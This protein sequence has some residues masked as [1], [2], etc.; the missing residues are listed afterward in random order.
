MPRPL[1]WVPIGGGHRELLVRLRGLLLLLLLGFP[2]IYLN[3]GARGGE[4]GLYRED[5]LRLY[6]LLPQEVFSLARTEETACDPSPLECVWRLFVSRAFWRVGCVVRGCRKSTTSSRRSPHFT[7]EDAQN[8]N[9]LPA[10]YM[11]GFEKPTH[12]VLSKIRGWF[13]GTT[14]VHTGDDYC[15]TALYS[16]PCEDKKKRE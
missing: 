13:T 14:Y 5:F 1:V 12:C 11:Q 16:A 4:A 3:H 6:R 10:D 7:V 2:P 8:R 9:I 15:E